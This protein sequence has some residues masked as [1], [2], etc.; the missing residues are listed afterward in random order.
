MR[1]E[2][3][4]PYKKIAAQL[5]VS[6]SSVFHWTRDIQITEEQRR[7]NLAHMAPSTDVVEKRAANWKALNRRR[8]EA[9]QRQGRKK[10]AEMDP[11]HMAGCM[12]YWAEGAK[13]RNSVIFIN[14]DVAMVSFFRHF[15]S[16]C[17]GIRPEDFTLR[18][19][20]YLGN[21]RSLQEIE[22]FWLGALELP[23]SDLRGHTVNHLPTSSSGRK[24]NKLPYGVCE[25]K[26]N[27]TRIVQHIYGAIQEY[28]G[29]EE[30][31][32]LD[33]PPRKPR[34]KAK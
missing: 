1:K 2:D 32:W 13:D 29:F 8:R 16:T 9:Y 4:L 12:L 3:G 31:R 21:G 20:V 26:L 23:R 11:L 18:L 28:G 24:R 27:S 7:R 25:L 17:F 34:K 6:P 5:G 30:S 22:S 19:N 15:V 33:G 14:S 10:A